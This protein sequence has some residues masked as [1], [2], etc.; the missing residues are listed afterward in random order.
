[1]KKGLYNAN[2]Y[3]QYTFEIVWEKATPLYHKI[4]EHPFVVEMVEGSL[5]REKYHAY[6][7]QDL[8]YLR[9]ASEAFK[10]TAE[11]TIDEQQKS[12]LLTV[13]HD[14][15]KSIVDY[16][17]EYK[18]KQ[19]ALDPVFEC[20]VYREHIMQAANSQNYFYN[21]GVLVPCLVSYSYVAN[22]FIDKIHPDNP[23]SR[24]FTQ[25]YHEF[26]QTAVPAKNFI[27]DLL[28]NANKAAYEEF[29][30]GF[31]ESMEMEILFWEG[32]YNSLALEAAS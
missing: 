27:N 8:L 18:I 5:P 28:R 12:F 15:E 11:R 6:L 20:H 1:M 31:K 17:K 7:Q 22:H 10:M 13:H 4:L 29:L 2:V 9:Y 3:D 26:E 30:R 14:I 24:W 25:N 23:Y 16:I 32:M 19:E 21:T